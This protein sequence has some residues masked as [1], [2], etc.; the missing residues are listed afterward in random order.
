MVFILCDTKSECHHQA[1]RFLITGGFFFSRKPFFFLL[2]FH[3]NY[4][5][6]YLLV[7]ICAEFFSIILFSNLRFGLAQS[8]IK[9]YWV[10]LERLGSTHPFMLFACYFPR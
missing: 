5:G 3:V 6:S 7:P 2:Y 8:A 1:A 4:F 9:V 10:L